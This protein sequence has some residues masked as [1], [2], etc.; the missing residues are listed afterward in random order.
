MW[1]QDWPYGW[2]DCREIRVVPRTSGRHLHPKSGPQSINLSQ[3]D[4]WSVRL[5]A[6]PRW[7]PSTSLCVLRSQARAGVLSWP[8]VHGCF[9]SFK[10]ILGSLMNTRSQPHGRPSAEEAVSAMPSC[11]RAR[12]I[13]SFGRAAP[14]DQQPNAPRLRNLRTRSDVPLPAQ[15]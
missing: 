8:M 9:R 1:M 5:L 12:Q 2:Q 7:G 15:R 6:G 14:T 11:E 3:V 13:P 10:E 4:V